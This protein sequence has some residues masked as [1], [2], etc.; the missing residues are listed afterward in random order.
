[1]KDSDPIS[2]WGLGGGVQHKPTSHENVYESAGK[3]PL[4]PG[5]ETAGHAH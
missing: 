3:L 5:E 1:M 4:F 2:K